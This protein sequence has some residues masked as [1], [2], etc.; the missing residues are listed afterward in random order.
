MKN[1]RLIL[2]A[3]ALALGTVPAAAQIQEIRKGGTPTDAALTALSNLEDAPGFLSNDG[4]GGF[5]WALV[6]PGSGNVI[7]T[8]PAIPGAVPVYTDETGVAINPSGVTIENGVM[9]VGGHVATNYLKLLTL[10]DSRVLVSSPADK[11]VGSVLVSGLLKGDGTEASASDITNALGMHLQG[12]FDAKQDLSAVLTRLNGIGLGTAGDILYRNNEGWTNL[13][14]GDDGQ[15]VKLEGGLP[16]WSADETAAGGEASGTVHAPDGATTA[17]RIALFKDITGTNITQAAVGISDLQAASAA[18]T[19]LA[20]DP[21]MYQATNANLTALATDPTIY[22]ATNANLT[23]L[24]AFGPTTWQ[25]TNANLTLLSAF[26]PTTWQAT[27]AALTALAADPNLYQATN[28]TL[29]EYAT[30]PTNSFLN[31]G[32]GGT[33]AGDL[34]VTGNFNSGSHSTD[35]LINTSMTAADIGFLSGIGTDTNWVRGTK[36]MWTN[37]AGIFGGDGSKYVGDDGETHDLPEGGSGNVINTGASTAGAIPVYSGTDGTNVAPSS[38]T[39]TGSTNVVAGSFQFNSG[40]LRLKTSSITNSLSMEQ[41]DSNTAGNPLGV[42]SVDLQIGRNAV[43]KVASGPNSFAVGTNAT[44]SG[45]YSIA[46]GSEPTASGNQS[47]AIGWKVTASATGSTALGSST[48]ASG[49]YATALGFATSAAINSAVAFGNSQPG[50]GNAQGMLIHLYGVSSSGGAVTLTT[51]GA[52]VPVVPLNSSWGFTIWLT[53]RGTAAGTGDEES[54]F[55][56]VEG[57]IEK[58][59][60]S[61]NTRIVGS[62]VTELSEDDAAW[63]VTVEANTTYGGLN[64]IF[65]ANGETNVRASAVIL[66]SHISG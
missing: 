44:A 45:N 56:K 2:F 66:V 25:A 39:I 35:L 60:T 41:P 19:A 11:S 1:S 23:A 55:Y 13:A 5:S 27:N 28:A 36:A 49:A 34:N 61:A 22:Q 29:T 40:G 12:L 30:I 32:T 9:S 65:T 14:K 48:T 18:L 3:L 24:S 63:T 26:G 57:L 21:T 6:P 15:V 7:S 17:N 38:V 33:V 16:K 47:T 50:A 53:A 10:T 46:M 58:D 4:L 8:G 37:T 31:V 43:A 42:G 20:S 59:N 54:G 51:D 52:S 62:T 64:V